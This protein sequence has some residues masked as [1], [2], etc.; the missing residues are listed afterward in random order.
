[1]KY[2]I[3]AMIFGLL[4]ACNPGQE[5][6]AAS[7]ENEVVEIV[8]YHD[9]GAVKIRGKNLRGKRTGVWQSYYPSGYKW[10][11]TSFKEGIKHGPT[12]TYYPNGVMRYDGQYYDDERN[13]FWT[14]YDTLGMAV[15]RINMDQ[16]SAKA[17]SL[18]NAAMQK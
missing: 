13:G 12:M 18:I 5:E 9:N 14:F 7:N 4:M 10:S 6:Q 3:W 1:M 8:E 16:A 17:D 15:E 11:E 2:S